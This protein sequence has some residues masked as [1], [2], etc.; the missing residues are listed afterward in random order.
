[1]NLEV[2]VGEDDARSRCRRKVRGLRKT[3]SVAIVGD[4]YGS[5]A[6]L[7]NFSTDHVNF[8]MPTKDFWMPLPTY[9][10]AAAT[11]NVRLPGAQGLL[12]QAKVLTDCAE[13]RPESAYG[14]APSAYAARDLP[15]PP[16]Y[17]QPAMRR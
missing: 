9:N 10:C 16:P 13:C 2:R 15:H 4:D 8:T 6:V 5:V 12:L 14:H 17:P 7:M 1:M 11:H 3:G